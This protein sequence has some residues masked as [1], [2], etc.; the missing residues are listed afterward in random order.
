MNEMNT[1]KL[2]AALADLIE[3]REDIASG[4]DEVIG[5]LS[6]LI[7]KLKSSDMGG[8]PE[9]IGRRG[10]VPSYIQQA[11]EYIST[12]GKPS[13]IEQIVAFIRTARNDEEI[14]R[15]SVESALARHIRDKGASA[16]LIKLG[17]GMYGLP[18]QAQRAL[19]L[20]G[21]SAPIN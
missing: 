5:A 10:E 11:I 16:S 20:N 8:Q 1:T 7:K 2:D 9:R 18:H 12:I 3:Q 6:G 15:G 14:K 21:T 17:R 13:H 19:T 4:F